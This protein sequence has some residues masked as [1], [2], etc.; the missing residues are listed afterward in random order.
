MLSGQRE[1]A[2]CAPRN[3]KKDALT[4]RLEASGFDVY[5][6]NVDAGPK[7]RWQRVLAGAYTDADVAQRQAARVNGVV[8]GAAAYVV[9]AQL[10]RS[11]S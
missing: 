6:V 1:I 9:D 8:P 10:L 11:G 3:G 2:A 5:Y 4:E 7:G